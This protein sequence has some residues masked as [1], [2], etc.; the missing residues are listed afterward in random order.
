MLSG[1]AAGRVHALIA[2][3]MPSAD[4]QPAAMGWLQR[5]CRVA[6]RELPA[7]GVGV[8]LISAAG[9]L[10][11]AAASGPRSVVLE[12]LQFTLGEGPCL[13]AYASRA[14]V[15]V[16]DLGAAEGTWPLYA[17][18]AHEHDV[19]AVFGFPLQVG[20]VRVGALDVYRDQPGDLSEVTLAQAVTFAESA[21]ARLLTATSD[22]AGGDELLL[23]VS[24]TRFEVY[25]A[26][27]MVMAQLGVDPEQ[28]M[29]RLR[30]HAFVSELRLAEVADGVLAGSIVLEPDDL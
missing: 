14:P 24:A 23:D 17:A 4:D 21:L 22:P 28:A 25:Q 11:T 16:P 26:Q 30:A 5:M 1:D 18:A 3:E 27:G 6:A 7:V 10:L 20:S 12:E 15:L 29:L 2:A 9:N 8:S 19:R 13:S